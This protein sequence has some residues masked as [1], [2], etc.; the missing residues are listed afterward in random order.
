MKHPER[1]GRGET[2]DTNRTDSNVNVFRKVSLRHTERKCLPD[3]CAS[4]NAVR[5]T[6]T[7]A[8]TLFI[9]SSISLAPIHPSNHPSFCA[10]CIH[11]FIP[12]FTHPPIRPLTY[13]FISSSMHPTHPCNIQQLLT[14]HQLYTPDIARCLIISSGHN[15]LESSLCDP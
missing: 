2:S 15:R 7:L 9:H 5:W 6:Q 10:C 3:T 12:L 11:P 14:R 4:C 8:T 13:P 1:R